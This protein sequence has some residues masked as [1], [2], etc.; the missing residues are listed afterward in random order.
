MP[1]L[2]QSPPR[3]NPLKRIFS[4]GKGVQ[5]P[6]GTRIFSLLNCRDSNS[7]LP[8]NLL[9]DFSLAAGEIE[10]G[11][12]SKIHVMPLVTQAT[13]VLQGE[14]EVWMKDVDQLEPYSLRLKAEQAI[15]TRPGTFLQFRNHTPVPCR[16]L[17]VVSPAYVFLMEGGRVA[18][19]DSVV[20]EEDWEELKRV[21]WMPEKLQTSGIT[22]EARRAAGEHLARRV[23]LP[24]PPS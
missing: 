16:V 8:G 12:D 20:L 4:V 3:R 11:R 17:Y 24:K 5:V 18:Y 7:G 2:P 21:N 23:Q 1:G 6:D 13:F 14:L 19:D 10:P 22:I 15:L 9:E